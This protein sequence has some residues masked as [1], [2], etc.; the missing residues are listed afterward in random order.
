MEDKNKMLEEFNQYI[1]GKKVAL[2][3][4]GVSNLPL[5]DYLY[6]K[7]SKVTV[8]DKKQIEDISKDVMDKIT[9]YNME[10]SF[11]ENYLE[12]LD[13]FDLIFRSPSCRPDTPEIEREVEKGA[14][15]TSEIELLL[16]MTPTHVIGVTGSQGKTTTTTLIYEVLT[17]T[18]FHCY[19]GGNIGVPLFTKLGEMTKDDIIILELSSF[20]L[21]DMEVSPD[22][23][24]ITNIA[25]NHLD[26]HKSFEEYIDAKKN[27][28]KFQNENGLLILN[29][30]DEVTR[31]FAKEAK[32]NVRFFSRVNKL[33]QGI[34]IEEGIIKEINN[35]VRRHIL[36]TG[37]MQLRGVHNQENAAAV[38]AV[39]LDLVDSNIY[40]DII[41]DFKGVEHRLEFIREL[42]EVKWYNDS[43]ASNPTRTVAGLNAFSE[44]IVL[45]AGGYDRNS[46][47]MPLAKPIVD[48]VKTLILIGPTKDKIYH[49]VEQEL[50]EQGKTLDI[51]VCDK[52]EDT[53]KLARKFAKPGQIVL[54]SPASASFDLFNN[55]EE[56]GKLFKDLVNN[57]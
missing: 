42:D 2:I 34:I 23:S 53:V 48:K 21:M 9:F 50:L 29:Y 56:R 54:L 39:T 43:I 49:A 41:C 46:D 27:I 1:K 11:G 57:L 25:P 33:D 6:N 47:Y 15:L 19:L 45:I 44:E 26:I 18:G 12:R 16:K 4:I 35:R 13:G 32:G 28:F 8:F 51:Y 40:K 5:L 37:D 20:Q 31:S 10:H 52:F 3:G 24:V 38:I 17:E 14:V 22:I 7:G 36:N 55:F 30:D